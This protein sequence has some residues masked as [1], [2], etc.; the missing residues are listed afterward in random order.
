MFQVTPAHE[1]SLPSA[2]ATVNTLGS[3]GDLA[4]IT[5]ISRGLSSNYT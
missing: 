1:R 2:Q 5:L 4:L 3:L